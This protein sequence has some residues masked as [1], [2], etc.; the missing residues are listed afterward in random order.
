L[1]EIL[2]LLKITSANIIKRIPNVYQQRRSVRLAA[3]DAML[4]VVTSYLYN[5]DL[6]QHK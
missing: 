1:I 5:V 2:Y 3:Y 4:K 6:M